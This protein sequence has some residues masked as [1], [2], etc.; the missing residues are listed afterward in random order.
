MTGH[1][2]WKLTSSEMK[3]QLDIWPHVLCVVLTGLPKPPTSRWVLLRKSLECWKSIRPQT[4]NFKFTFK[5]S[6]FW[7]FF[8]KTQ[9][10]RTKKNIIVGFLRIARKKTSQ[11]SIRVSRARDHQ[12]QLPHW[13]DDTTEAYRGE[14]TCYLRSRWWSLT[15]ACLPTLEKKVLLRPYFLAR[16]VAMFESTQPST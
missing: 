14:A 5:Q 7:E 8:S 11:C 6:C 9:G 1:L 16:P 15:E 4:P 2:R 13:K 10:H 12:V 3:F